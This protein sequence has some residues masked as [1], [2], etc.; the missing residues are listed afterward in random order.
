MAKKNGKM[1]HEEIKKREP[2]IKAPFMSGYTADVSGHKG[3][4]GQDA[5][6]VTKPILPRE[7]LKQVQKA[8][9][10]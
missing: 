2:G 8:L 5:G 1:V 4:L 9:G 7:L 6:I 3:I 10:H